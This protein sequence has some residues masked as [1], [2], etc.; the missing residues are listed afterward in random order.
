MINDYEILVYTDGKRS[1]VAVSKTYSKDEAITIA[2]EHF[3]TK[4]SNLEIQS[5]K[6]L[7]N[8]LEFDV[9]GQNSCWIVS[10]RCKA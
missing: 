4:K 3:K 7:K 10:R 5:G 6:A 8:R 2:N 1:Y 9:N